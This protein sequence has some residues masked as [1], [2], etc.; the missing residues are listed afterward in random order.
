MEHLPLL[1]LLIALPLVGAVAVLAVPSGRAHL[2]RG[3]AT[4]AALLPIA[5]AMLLWFAFEPR[6]AQWQFSQ[7]VDLGVP[8]GVRY[9]VGLDGLSL[10]LAVL[11]TAVVAVAIACGPAEPARRWAASLLLLEAGALGAF[12]SLDVLQMFVFWQLAV[13]ALV[14][15][16]AASEPRRIAV[17]SMA[18]AIAGGVL[19][20]AGVLVLR[21]DYQALASIST[22][23][24]R[25]Y[26]LASLPRA[27]QSR[28]FLLLALAFAAPLALALVQLAT[29][30]HR[31]SSW[32]LAL[33]TSAVVVK[34]GA[35]GFL[36]VLMPVVPEVTRAIAPALVLVGLV[37]AAIVACVTVR[38]PARLALCLVGIGQL[39]VATAGMFAATPEAL[40]GAMVHLFAHGIAI[41]ALFA[42][43]LRPGSGGQAAAT[44]VSPGL[45][46]A[47]AIAGGFTGARLIAAGLLPFGRTTVA[48]SILANVVTAA[49]LIVVA[50]RSSSAGSAGDSESSAVNL[51]AVAP[52]IALSVAMAVYPAP[53]LA[54]LET[55]VARLV[56]RV[57]PEYSTQVADCLNQPVP[58]P[59]QNSGLP[60]GMMLAAP[61]ADGSNKP[62]GPAKKP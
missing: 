14:V 38:A 25:A 51:A 10:M 42:I 30:L 1:F 47:A 56:M 61:C 40:T 57:S 39:A 41:A 46:A 50:R 8:S 23:D 44:Y 36:R 20:L 35:F 33:V 58:P 27:A 45:V 59:P 48:A 21:A 2:V 24:I 11:T 3:L 49:A 6:G 31:R 22:F 29:D 18:I 55:S 28:V 9:A 12:V 4:L 32:L 17:L 16:I 53:L 26:H 43:A 7:Q 34:L 60:G 19:M 52:L 5:I 37:S 15:M 54:R 13:V 62:G